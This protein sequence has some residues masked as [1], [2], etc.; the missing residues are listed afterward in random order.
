MKTSRT[1]EARGTI[2]K[3]KPVTRAG[4]CVVHRGEDGKAY[5]WNDV[6]GG[7]LDPLLTLKAREEEM[8][9]F[10]KHEVYEKVREDVCWAVTG[11]GPIGSRWIDINKGDESNPD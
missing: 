2:G 11:K 3:V 5:A 9:Q 8:E 4:I 6:S 7:E 1:C 10:R